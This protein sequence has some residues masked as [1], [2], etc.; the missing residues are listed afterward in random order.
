MKVD[1]RNPLHWLLLLLSAGWVMLAICLRPLLHRSMR[2]GRIL[3]YGHKLGGNLLAI[4]R[5]LRSSDAGL[6]VSFL[7]MDPAYHRELVARGEASV[8]SASPASLPWLVGADALISDHGLHALQPLVDLS[9]MKFFDVWH[10]IPFKG[11]DADDFRVL[12]RYEEAWVASPLLARLYADKYGFHPGKVV[13]TGYARTDRLVKERD[14]ATGTLR[15]RMGLPADA[16]KVILFAPT[17]KQDSSD[18]SLFPF[19]MEAD[20]FCNALSDLSCRLGA[21][22]VLRT[23]INSGRGSVDVSRFRRLASL[24]YADHPDTEEIL[25]ATDVLVCDWSSIAFDYLLLDRP[26][27]FLD[28]P[29][30]F[31]K[32]F[33]L[34]PEYRFGEVVP[35]LG[36]MLHAIELAVL[37]PS[38][39]MARHGAGA[40]TARQD[41]YGG[42]ADG[43]AAARCVER[44]KAALDLEGHRHHA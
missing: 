10:A 19:G 43:N 15:E 27:V 37:A 12:H 35:D 42:F 7:T 32:G 17:W 38:D 16:G 18:R 4:Q 13:V 24:P 34:G 41:V 39:Y 28:V 3:L 2:K 36:A 21:T 22:V 26:T 6:Q 25:L 40:R 29:A 11:F 8:L 23:H 31:K 14:I 1:R 44:L 33:T 9:D 30:P 20:A 5:H